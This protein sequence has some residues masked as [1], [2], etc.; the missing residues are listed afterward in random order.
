MRQTASQSFCANHPRKGLDQP[1]VSKKKSPQKT[2]DG[3]NLDMGGGHM[4]G[5]TH[6][7]SLCTLCHSDTPAS[8]WNPED[9]WP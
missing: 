5:V 7:K 4:V 3:E 6:V 1:S 2:W 8:D 9:G